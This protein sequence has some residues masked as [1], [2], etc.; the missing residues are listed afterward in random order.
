M[1]LVPPNPKDWGW[2]KDDRGWHPLWTTLPEASESC[3][4]LVHRGCNKGC[5]MR[6]KCVKA[7]IKCTYVLPYVENA[8]IFAT[9]YI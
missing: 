6:R 8:E 5:T 3:R 1:S 7:S 4:E 2:W 9:V